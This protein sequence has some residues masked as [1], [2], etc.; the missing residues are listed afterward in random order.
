MKKVF[1]LLFIQISILG[2]TQEEKKFGID[3]HGYVKTDIFFDSR[4]TVDVR[5]GHFLLYPQNEVLDF[6]G[7]D[8]NATPKFNIL[9]IQTRL[10]GKISGPDV[11]GA[12][13]SGL[14]EGAFFGNISPNINVFRLRH[15]FV[16]LTWEKA[17][18]LVGQFWHPMFI[19]SSYPGTVSFNTGAPIQPFTRNPQIRFTK[20]F[21]Q[22]NI[23]GTLIEQVD[24]VSTGPGGASPKYLINSCIPEINLRLEYSS[25]NVLIG[26]GGN[27]KSLMPRLYVEPSASDILSQPVKAK[28]SE[29][30][31]GLSA[32]AYLKVKTEP[33]TFKLYGVWGQ[34]MYSMTGLGGYAEKTYDYQNITDTVYTRRLE[35]ITY[36]PI[37]IFS[38]W[39]DI[40]TNGDTWQLGLFAGLTKNLGAPDVI[41][42]NYYGRGKDISYIYRIAPRLIYTNG[43]F[44][45]APEIEYTVAAYATNDELGELNIDYHG[46][47]TD[48]KE[49]PN[50]RFLIGVYYMF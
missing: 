42:G 20:K 27:Y 8:I 47:I 41:T 34:M 50:F 11:L 40:N 6:E 26:V 46:V 39:T 3:F 43:K 13:T 1:L 35:N 33:L 24:F 14:I 16:K 2:F 9:S 22:I 32:F 28:T 4:Q 25:D 19:T 23:L 37:S 31:S 29:R 15:A 38:A 36:T 10:T 45:I 48:S 30:V 5:E 18:L 49:I 17:E 7:N 21:G 12:K 44:R